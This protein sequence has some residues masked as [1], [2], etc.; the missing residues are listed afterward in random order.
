MNA[1]LRSASGAAL[2]LLIIPIIAGL[3]ACMPVPVGDPERSRA[4][5]WFQGYWA[6]EGG[7]D[8][9]G[10]YLFAPWDK[11]TWV[12][13]GIEVKAGPGADLAGL[14]AASAAELLALLREH[15]VGE[16]G[17]TAT[18]AIVYKAWTTKL[19][20]QS[21]MTWQGAAGSRDG[22]NFLPEFWWV[23]KFEKQD[24][25]TMRLWLIDPDH[26]AFDDIVKPRDYEG[27][28]YHVKMRKTWE[29]AIRKNIDDE[30]LFSEEYL[31]MRRVPPDMVELV[32]ELFQE[33]VEFQ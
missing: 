2:M 18:G 17:L 26:D 10:L 21:F 19:D 5:P 28:D 24:A 9:D 23:W 4:D 8:I 6:L 11:R 12:L 13:T 29:R 15:D 14:E 20:G 27:D 30:E 33:V 1:R 25:N 16:D 32:E 22:G 7:D 31:V 3:L